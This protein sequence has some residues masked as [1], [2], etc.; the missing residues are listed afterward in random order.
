MRLHSLIGDD[1]KSIWL[2]LTIN[3]AEFGEEVNKFSNSLQSLATYADLNIAG[4]RKILKQFYKQVPGI[5]RIPILG[6]IEYRIL[7]TE[8]PQFLLRLGRIREETD[9]VIQAL[10]PG[11]QRLIPVSLGNESLSALEGDPSKEMS[12]DAQVGSQSST[13]TCPVVHA[14]GCDQTRRSIDIIKLGYASGSEV[15]EAMIKLLKV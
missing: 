2:S 12:M 6:V 15:H 8:F 3:A 9:E 10:S 1:I 5:Y 7:A 14:S 4:F 11:T 13:L